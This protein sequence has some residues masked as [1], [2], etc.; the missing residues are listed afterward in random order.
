[1]LIAFDG[2]PIPGWPSSRGSIAVWSPRVFSHGWCTYTKI[3]IRNLLK[4][5]ILKGGGW[6]ISCAVAHAYSPGYSE[7]E[8]GGSTTPGSL[9][10]A[11]AI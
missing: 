10:S 5:E 3:K 7:A 1:M 11:K 9:R 6:I 4:D 8:T 2:A